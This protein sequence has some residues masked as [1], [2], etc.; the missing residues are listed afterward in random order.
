MK[1]SILSLLFAGACLTAM[2]QDIRSISSD[3]GVRI[4]MNLYQNTTATI[5]Q[6]NLTYSGNPFIEEDLKEGIVTIGED[7]KQVFFMRYNVLNERIEFSKTND[8]ATLKALPKIEDLVIL[9]EGKTYQYIESGNLPAGYYEIV[10][11][12]DADTFLLVEH[13]KNIMEVE[14]KSSYNSGQK[15]KIRS[16]E[17]IFFFDNKNAIEID[18]HK[19]RSVNA[20]PESTQSELK[21]FIQD[22]KIKFNDDYKGLIAIIDKYITL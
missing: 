20:F 22:N 16:S 15:S 2:A 12:F 3:G 1:K 10:K 11:A 8:V 7:N 13:D 19:K 6:S 17:T 9:L 14:Q 4:D 5:N 18:N 21:S